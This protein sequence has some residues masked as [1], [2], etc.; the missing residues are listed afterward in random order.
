M[1]LLQMTISEFRSIADQK[2]A[3][4]GLVVLFGPNSAGKTSALEAAEHLI[5]RADIR[6]VDPA[7]RWDVNVLGS[8]AYALPDAEMPGSADADTYRW[9][10][11]DLSPRSGEFILGWV[12]FDGAVEV[13]Q[14]LVITPLGRQRLHAG[15]R[16]PQSTCRAFWL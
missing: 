13:G 15:C 1:R 10:L 3:L 2:L 4:T 11:A 12:E 14:G 8:V 7:E 6:R 16:Q 5:T 9:L